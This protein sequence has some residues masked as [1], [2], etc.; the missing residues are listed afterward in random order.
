MGDFAY[1][2]LVFYMIM[3]IQPLLLKYL[4]LFMSQNDSTKEVVSGMTQPI[5]INEHKF[6]TMLEGWKDGLINFGIRVLLAIIFFFLARWVMNVIIRV[7]KGIMDRRNLTGVAVSLINSIVIALLYIAVGIAVISILGVKSVSLA[8]VLASMG[9]AVGMA[10]SGQLQNLAGG[11]IIVVTKPFAIGDFIQAQNVEGTV[12]SVSLFHT[13][14]TTIENKVIFIP[15]GALSSGVIINPTAQDTRRLQ[16]TFGIDYDSDVDKAL[17]I[18]RELL[19]ADER[20]LKENELYIGVSALNASSVDILV[21]A[22]V[23]VSDVLAVTHGF[24]LTVFHAFNEVGISFPFP[25][26]TV[27]HRKE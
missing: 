20:V 22:W 19:E 11:V 3:Q 10:L 7:L 1:N 15:N 25:Q 12:K 17:V 26:I 2:F 5:H 6:L 27:S 16:W 14:I 21:R 9:L 18:L 24:N 13:V 23:N 4:P 8:A